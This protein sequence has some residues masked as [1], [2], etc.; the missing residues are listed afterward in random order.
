[1]VSFPDAAEIPFDKSPGSSI[2]SKW[3]FMV[4]FESGRSQP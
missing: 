3:I 1:M 4:E 2:I